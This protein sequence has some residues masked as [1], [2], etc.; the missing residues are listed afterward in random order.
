MDPECH[1]R[2]IPSKHVRIRVLVAESWQNP[3]RVQYIANIVQFN[4]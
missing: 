2:W 4:I 1:Y 3:Q